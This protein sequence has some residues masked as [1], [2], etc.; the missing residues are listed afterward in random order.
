MLHIELILIIFFKILDQ[1]EKLHFYYDLMPCPSIGPKL[2]WIRSKFYWHGSNWV[3]Q[4][5]KLFLVQSKTLV[6]NSFGN[7]EG[8]GISLNLLTKSNIGNLP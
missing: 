1:L 3:I 5:W 4:F 7:I 2:F 6:K 8:Q